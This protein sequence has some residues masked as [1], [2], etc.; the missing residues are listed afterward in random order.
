MIKDRQMLIEDCALEVK[1]S[2]LLTAPFLLELLNEM[3]RSEQRELR[4]RLKLIITHQLKWDYQPERRSDS[5]VST[6]ADNKLEIA[7]MLQESPS[8]FN[9]LKLVY[10]DKK[11]YD[12]AKILAEK[13]TR[14]K[15]FPKENPYSLEDILNL[16]DNYNFDE[17]LFD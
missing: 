9:K 8:L 4:S 14:L 6:I 13:E 2:N 11:L 16:E 5:W 15:K 17:S 10:A 3:S 7:S 12:H 1:N